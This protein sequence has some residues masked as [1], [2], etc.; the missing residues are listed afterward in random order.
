MTT[1]RLPVT[2]L[3][4]YLGTGKTTLVNHLLRHAAGRRIAVLVNDFGT[5]PI[6]ADLIKANDAGVLSLAGGCVCCSYGDD[7]VAALMEMAKR[8]PRP[9][10]VLIET[11]GV[12][13]PGSVAR[14][15]TLMLDYALDAVVVLADA[16]TTPARLT[17]PYIA[18]T[19]TRQFSDAD[20]IVLNKCDLVPPDT[21]TALIASLGASYRQARVLAATHARLSPD[22]V[23]GLDARR[24]LRQTI[25]APGHRLEAY[26]EASFTFDGQIRAE[27]LAAGLTELPLVRAKGF[28]ETAPGV[29]TTLQLAGRRTSLEPAPAGLIGP[30][31]LVCIAHGAPLDRAAIAN[32]IRATGGTLRLVSSTA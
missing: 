13:I 23:L 21:S 12:A 22:V 1:P 26:A 31:R 3:G 15:L 10:H 2:I 6:D 25:A 28:V 11:S 30:N 32:L 16:E 7:L 8:T 18:D 27:A 29:W 9:D 4:G 14:S 20:L 19:L 24:S 17:D 5:L